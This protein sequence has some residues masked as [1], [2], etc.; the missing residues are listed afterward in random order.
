MPEIGIEEDDA[1]AP[2]IEFRRQ[3]GPEV[4]G[5]HADLHQLA[6]NGV[7]GGMRTVQNQ[8]SPLIEIV[9]VPACAHFTTLR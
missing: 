1:V 2:G 4:V 3:V 9:C 6:E 7:H 8:R 5:F